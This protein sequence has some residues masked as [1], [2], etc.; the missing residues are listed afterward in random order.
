MVGTSLCAK[1]I[2]VSS[3]Y[4]TTLQSF[5]LFDKSLMKTKNNK[6]PNTDPC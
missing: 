4:K 3:A 1:K 5:I 2:A 6:G